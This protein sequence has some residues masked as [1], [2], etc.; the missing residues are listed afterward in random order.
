M[1]L[2]GEKGG[3]LQKRIAGMLS[4]KILAFLSFSTFNDKMM[5]Q[6]V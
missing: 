2:L 4:W 5:Q 6:N 1:I 3:A